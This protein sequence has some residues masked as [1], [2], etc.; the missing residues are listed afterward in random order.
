M[1]K[2]INSLQQR[3]SLLKILIFTLV[4]IMIWVLLSI[5][6]TQQRTGV[7]EELLQLAEPLNPNINLDVLNRIGQK[8]SYTPEELA[9]FPVYKQIR[10]EAGEEEIVT[11]LPPSPTPPPLTAPPGTSGTSTD[12]ATLSPE[13]PTQ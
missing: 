11:T 12:S 10:N 1:P 4:T 7:S 9:N 3:Q 2:P 8:R 6:R 13:T 5:F